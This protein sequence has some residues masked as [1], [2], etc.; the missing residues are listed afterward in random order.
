M[1]YVPHSE[2]NKIYK[3]VAM[4][5]KLSE[6]QNKIIYDH[7]RQK[8]NLMLSSLQHISLQHS[9]YVEEIARLTPF[10]EFKY[11]YKT[12]Y[13]SDYTAEVGFPWSSRK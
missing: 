8:T 13:V 10:Y 1:G 4:F 2:Y 5:C 11:V 6:N 12:L 3:D 9:K 7:I